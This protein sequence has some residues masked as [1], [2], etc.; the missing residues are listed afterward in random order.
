MLQ[1]G[2]LPKRKNKKVIGLIKEE[3]GKQIM[4]EFVGLRPKTQ[5]FER[6]QRLR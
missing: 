1:H 6:Q 3:L 5:L 2:S 4:T